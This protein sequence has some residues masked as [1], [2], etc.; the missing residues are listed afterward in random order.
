M[1]ASLLMTR[2]SLHP[3]AE[4]HQQSTEELRC[5]IADVAV[6]WCFYLVSLRF[7]GSVSL[8]LEMRKSIKSSV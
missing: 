5:G 1:A 8:C 2:A 4:H 7:I 3:L 6:Y